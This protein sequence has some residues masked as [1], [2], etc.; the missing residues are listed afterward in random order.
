M[1]DYITGSEKWLYEIYGCLNDLTPDPAWRTA[2]CGGCGYFVERDGKSKPARGDCRRVTF[3]DDLACQVE[4]P[5]CP[6]YCGK[7]TPN[8]TDS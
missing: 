8:E 7:E 1:S 2:K 4:D 3:Q 6:A 5:A